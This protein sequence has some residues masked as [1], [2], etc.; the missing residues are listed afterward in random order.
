MSIV[1][2]WG[3][4]IDAVVCDF[5][6]PFMINMRKLFGK[7]CILNECTEYS[8]ENCF[9]VTYKDHVKPCIDYTIQD[10]LRNMTPV[11]GA[12][13][14]IKHYYEDSGITPEFV[15][16]RD[17]KHAQIT[18]EWLHMYL[19][20]IPFNLHFTNGNKS[21][22]LIDN[23]I[24]IFVEDRA[25]YAEQLAEKEICVFLMNWPWNQHCKESKYIERVEDWNFIR[26]FYDQRCRPKL[27]SK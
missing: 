24:N 2:I 22:M 17:R 12:I 15:T 6:R 27:E 25:R 10:S 26:A 16:C 8:F 1:P 11:S 21:Q 13:S 23:D 7:R 19:K 9:D 18:A 5:I 20:P 3:W 14:F 4:D